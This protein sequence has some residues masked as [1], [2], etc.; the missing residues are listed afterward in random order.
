MKKLLLALALLFLPT[1]AHAGVSCSLPFNLTNGTVG[2]AT[3]VMANYNAILSCLSTS[4]AHSGAN[5]DITSL[6][7]VVPPITALC[8]VT[9]LT[10]VNDSGTP[11]TKL[12]V[13][14]TQAVT[15][16]SAS[17]VQGGGTASLV[18]NLGTASAANALD[19]GSLSASTTYN[20]F[21]IGNG[22]T[23]ATLGSLSATAPTLPSGYT[24]MCRI[25]AWY[26]N[27]ASQLVTAYIAGN[28]FMLTQ[29]SGGS[30]SNITAG[31]LQFITGSI[32]SCANFSTDTMVL[33]AFSGIPV[34]ATEAI[35]A[36]NAGGAGAFVSQFGPSARIESEIG[37]ITG[38]YQFDL[39]LPTAQSIYLCTVNG[40]ISVMGWVD[41]V[42]AH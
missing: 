29:K 2:D 37:G 5:S 9:G 40:T 27:T 19:T 28:K 24:S 11:N 25:G 33:T 13:K 39:A 4:T 10:I 1:G 14:F 6:L 21:V 41:G 30:G 8:G 3:Q 17:A 7:G 22:S 36:V 18:L 20:L 26:T 12:D 32:G 31:A 15:I 16:T 23:I 34:T 38:D 42:N 35:G